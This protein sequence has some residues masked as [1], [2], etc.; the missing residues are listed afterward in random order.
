MSASLL[1][2]ISVKNVC[3]DIK[4]PAIGETVEKMVIM[5]YA[6]STEIKKTTFG[7]SVGFHGDFK[8]I[9]VSTG[10]EFRSGVCY[11]PDVAEN[12][13][14]NAMDDA[15]GAVVEFGFSVSV[16]GV[17]GRTPEEPTKYEYR[18]KPLTESAEN[19]PLALLEN[20]IKAT[21]L[22]SETKALAAPGAKKGGK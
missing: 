2:K 15:G 21:A 22:Q 13:L 6:K 1:K 18:C 19:D 3:G 5:G 16:I 20:R 12:L 9:D 8:A 7:D 11:L 17:K 10:E 4:A 14:S